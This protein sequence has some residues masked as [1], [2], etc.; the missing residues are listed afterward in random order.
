MKP[1]LDTFSD[2]IN[3]GEAAETVLSDV[4]AQYKTIQCLNV[5]LSLIRSRC[6]PTAEYTKAVDDAVANADERTRVRVR[7]LAASGQRL[8]AADTSEVC[9]IMKSLPPRL[10]ENARKLRLTRTEMRECKRVQQKQVVEKNRVRVVVSGRTLLAHARDV[11]TEGRGGIPELTLSLMLLT[12][13]RECELLNGRSTFVPHTL[14]SLVFEGQAKK[15]DEGVE[16]RDRRLI[17]CLCSSET[18]CRCVGVLRARQRH[19][20]LSNEKT[21][22]RYQS[23]LS[24]HMRTV[25]PWQETK[26]H[27]HSL[28][29]IYTSMTHSLFDW[30]MHTNAF[31]SMCIL[32]HTS[33][34]ES[35]VYTTFDIGRDFCE[36]PHLGMGHLTP[37]LEQR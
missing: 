10:S 18:I 21:S 28:R 5:K 34:T 8:T 7:A 9:E 15:R 6:H 31:V 19:V 3:N 33:L 4:R 14:H 13:R 16:V 22:R 30:G 36:E 24:H 32:G 37:P 12:G 26:T 23:S 11:V 2:R 35:L 17:P 27:V 25:S 20:L 1:L 29:G